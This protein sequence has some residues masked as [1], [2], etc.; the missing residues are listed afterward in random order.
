MHRVVRIYS[1][2][3]LLSSLQYILINYRAISVIGFEG[4]SYSSKNIKTKKLLRRTAEVSVFWTVHLI[5]SIGVP[6][7]HKKAL[8]SE[9]KEINWNAY[10]EIQKSNGTRQL[11]DDNT[12]IFV[13]GNLVLLIAGTQKLDQPTKPIF[14]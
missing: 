8:S 11:L 6:I 7:S 3:S 2:L 1:K 12:T 14:L 5:E 4:Y 13:G 9:Q 10:S